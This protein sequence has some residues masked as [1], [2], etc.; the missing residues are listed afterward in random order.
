MKREIVVTTNQ[1]A[2]NITRRLKEAGYKK[3]TDCYWTMIFE[4]GG[5]QVIVN[6]D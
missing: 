5:D 1:E 6:R 3:I 2:W 4:K